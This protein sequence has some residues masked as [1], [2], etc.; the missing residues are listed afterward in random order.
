MVIPA[1]AGPVENNKA[2]RIETIK[3][4]MTI[5]AGEP[6]ELN[7]VDFHCGKPYVIKKAV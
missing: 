1:R 4:E 2:K 7:L 3:S 6:C 5:L